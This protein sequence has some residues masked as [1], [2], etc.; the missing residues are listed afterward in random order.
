MHLNSD[1]NGQAKRDADKM[2]KEDFSVVTKQVLE[3]FS[4]AK[5]FIKP[6]WNEWI[7]RLKLY[8]NQR[9]NNETV[10]DPLLFR[11]HQTVLASLYNDE[12]Q[13]DFLPREIGDEDMA[14]NLTSLAAFDHAEMKKDELD[15]D[16]DW[17]ATFY[18][19]ALCMM[20]EWNKKKKVPVPEC[21][22]MMTFLRDPR[23]VSINGKGIKRTNSARFFGR[24]IRLTKREMKE[25]PKFKN[26]EGLK[27]SDSRSEF[28]E[29]RKLRAE[30]QGVN[31]IMRQLEG[32]NK[33]FELLEWFTY[34]KGKKTIITIPFSSRQQLD[35]EP[36][37]FQV[38]EDQTKWPVIDRVIYPMPDTWDGVS[39]ADLVEDKQRA[40]AVS[41]NL[42][43]FGMKSTQYP[44]Y[45]F[46]KS[47]IK[48]KGDLQLG[49][50]KFIPI[51]GSV[52]GAIAEVPKQQIKQDVDYILGQ[53]EFGAQ[54]ATATPELQQG[55]QAR[56]KRTATELTIQQGKIDTRFSLSARIF[57]WSEKRLWRQ[58]LDLYKKHFSE[59]VDK[60]MVRITGGALN[61]IRPFRRKDIIS[62]TDPDIIVESKAASDAKRLVELNTRQSFYAQIAQDPDVDR[63]FLQ[64]SI[65]RIVGIRKQE[66]NALFP[67]TGEEILAEQ[68]NV[69][70]NK[71]QPVTITLNDDDRTHLKFHQKANQTKATELHVQAHIRN[72]K[73]KAG[74][75]EVEER[76]ARANGQLPAPQ[77]AVPQPQATNSQAP[78]QQLN[79]PAP[80]T[81]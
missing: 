51:D 72:L 11:I 80:Q 41:L 73:L 15:Y 58:W 36:V 60:K 52:E 53:L 48:N 19:H 7:V 40:R 77:G 10:G 34:W 47:K 18:G 45:L 28:D 61:Q 8:N 20:M 6:K 37:R 81:L 5:D 42:A 1:D 69:R 33:D 55:I 22:D 16:W 67:K 70:L 24:V 65:A 38:L 63:R 17:G 39:V 30:A 44:M 26:F 9:R 76:E 75:R 35:K 79:L 66:M 71:N 49:F 68:E 14:D 64:R 25:N 13:V 74:I 78:F 54:A 62:K 12:L 56:S 29:N 23:A 31:P 4:L 46:N 2:E 21:M 27:S 59:G 57:G 32:E 43:L 50:N 3:E